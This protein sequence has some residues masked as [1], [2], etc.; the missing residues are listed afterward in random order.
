MEQHEILLGKSLEELQGLCA[1]LGFR[2]FTARQICAW[3]YQKRVRDIAQMTNLSLK[4]RAILEEAAETGIHEP[5]QAQQSADGTKKYLFASPGSEN[6]PGQSGFIESVLIPDGGRATLCVSSQSGCRMNCAFCA[7]GSQ[8]FN[9]HLPANQILN[10]ILAV[11][12]SDF[13]TNLVFMGMGEPFDNIANVLKALQALT[14][15]WGW[16]WSPTRITVSTVGI[17]PQ[18]P[19]FME[20]CRCHLAISLHN[21]FAD[22]RAE[23]MPVEKAYP[24]RELVELLKTYDDWYGQRRVSFEYIL[25]DGFNDTP[26][27]ALATARLLHG[28]PCRVNL[29]NYHEVPG[30]PYRKSSPQKTESFQKILQ[31]KGI[32]CT[33]RKSRGEDI[34]AACGLLAKTKGEK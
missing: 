9:H 26:R 12:E 6:R 19:R 22:E 24:V 3:I 11:P 30:K 15:P 23:L 20:E 5:L 31:E 18:L 13:L 27:H 34:M 16:A 25:I 4:D 1:E 28:L 17:T 29:I 21:P 10:Q 2:K 7:T 32:T 8:G 33:L 14:A